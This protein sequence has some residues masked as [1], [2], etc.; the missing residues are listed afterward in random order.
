MPLSNA[1]NREPLHRLVCSLK[2]RTRVASCSSDVPHSATVSYDQYPNLEIIKA[3]NRCVDLEHTFINLSLSTRSATWFVRP[4]RELIQSGEKT[5]TIRLQTSSCHAKC[6]PRLAQ[7]LVRHER[8]SVPGASSSR[9]SAVREACLGS[10][11]M[12]NAEAILRPLEIGVVSL[13]PYSSPDT[14]FFLYDRNL[15]SNQI[16]ANR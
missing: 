1:M 2:V 8:R 10:I 11:L 12:R 9:I 13:L 15:L 3:A 4:L 14:V 7:G 16:G 5:V 6:S